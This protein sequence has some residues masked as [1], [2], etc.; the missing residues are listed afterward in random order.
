VVSFSEICGRE[1]S[2]S[3]FQPRAKW[4]RRWGKEF[5]GRVG[6][7]KEARVRKMGVGCAS[8]LWEADFRPSG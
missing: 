8:L 2:P 7:D 1:S 4:L 6:M 3:R 5:G